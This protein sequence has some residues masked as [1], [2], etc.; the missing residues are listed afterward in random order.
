MTKEQ[1]LALTLTRPQRQ[2]AEAFFQ[3]AERT[4][5]EQV[6]A[7]ATEAEVKAKLNE[8]VI[9][10]NKRKQRETK[11]A[12][13]DKKLNAEKKVV[14]EAIE[15]A[16]NNGLSYAEIAEAL[17]VVIKQQKNAKLQAQIEALQAQLE[18]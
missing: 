12:E 16:R 7:G 13:Q 4:H 8:M 17:A 15:T 1:V 14:L 6:I 11:K 2:R 10:Y 5:K 9:A 18:E 3:M